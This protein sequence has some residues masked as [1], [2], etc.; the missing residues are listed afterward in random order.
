MANWLAGLRVSVA[1]KSAGSVRLSQ[2]R[3]CPFVGRPFSVLAE[4]GEKLTRPRCRE[5]A[6]VSD[7]VRKS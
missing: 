4:V 5:A 3:G 1:A 2:H 7:V 6:D